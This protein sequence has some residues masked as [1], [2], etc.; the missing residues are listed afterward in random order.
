MKIEVPANDQAVYELTTKSG[1][2]YLVRCPGASWNGDDRSGV[3]AL[4]VEGE[5]E[6]FVM[7]RG[8]SLV[9]SL[10]RRP[11]VPVR[12]EA[13]KPAKA[14]ELFW[15]RRSGGAAGIQLYFLQ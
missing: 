8:L 12:A 7:L 4:L 6:M 3:P 5:V 14:R 2:K 9:T 15:K 11:D 13:Q 1:R 10:V